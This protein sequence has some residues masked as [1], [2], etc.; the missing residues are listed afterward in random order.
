M[1]RN[2]PRTQQKLA[3]LYRVLGKECA[4]AW[5]LGRIYVAVFQAVLLYGL[6]E[7]VMTPHIGRLLG[8]LHHR[9]DCILTEQK[10]QRG[11]DKRWVYLLLTEAMGEAGLH[12]VE[13]YVSL[14]QNTV[15]QFIS[16]RPIMELCLAAER[17]LGSPVANWWWEKEGL[18]LE[19]MPTEAWET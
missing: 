14:C 11:R 3:R 8:G 9:V 1:V 19:E 5:I 10:H 6:E 7:S 12:E 13:K 17:H 15:A 2:I 16:N 4:D 18:D